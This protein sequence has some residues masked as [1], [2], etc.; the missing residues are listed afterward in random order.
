MLF[1]VID[2]TQT[3]HLPKDSQ[4]C[5]VL[6]D[7]LTN[8]VQPVILEGVEETFPWCRNTDW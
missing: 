4:K 2:K 7:I 5:P 1:G 6:A 3:D 8:H